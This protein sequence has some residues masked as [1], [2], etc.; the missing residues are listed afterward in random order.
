VG[1]NRNGTTLTMSLAN[2]SFDIISFQASSAYIFGLQIR[3]DGSRNNISTYG[4]T[5]LLQTQ[6]RSSIQL[7]WTNIDTITISSI[8]S[9]YAG[10]QF[11]MDNLIVAFS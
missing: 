8:P 6:T 11:I 9:G 10:S 1:L 3:I 7:N 4:R 5:F 2:S